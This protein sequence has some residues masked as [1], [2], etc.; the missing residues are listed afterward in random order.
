M[1]EWPLWAEFVRLLCFAR[2]AIFNLS[3]DE[4]APACPFLLALRLGSDIDISPLSVFGQL[5]SGCCEGA[6][7]FCLAS[8]RGRQ[9]FFWGGGG[10]ESQFGFSLIFFGG[11]TPIFWY[12][13]REGGQR[14]HHAFDR[15]LSGCCKGQ[16][17]ETLTWS[18]F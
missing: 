7:P 15:L 3:L 2:I 5:S 11:L 18:G 13:G 17:G 9:P 10:G 8:A 12:V 1:A 16:K 4:C 14:H 6:L